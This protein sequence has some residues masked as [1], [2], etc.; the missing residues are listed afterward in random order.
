MNIF[1]TWVSDRPRLLARSTRSGVLKYFCDSNLF[2]STLSCWSL[3]TVL[4]FRRLHS[5]I[6]EFDCVP[7]AFWC[8]LSNWHLAT[9]DEAISAAV[10]LKT[11]KSTEYSNNFP[12]NLS[13][14][15]KTI[16][17]LLISAWENEESG[18]RSCLNPIL[19]SLHWP[20]SLRLRLLL[21]FRPL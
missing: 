21:L 9:I 17:H 1:T 2:S 11:K 7:P 15:I 18:R 12:K 3:N 6:D 19:G 13:I 14:Y 8:T 4:A 20:L 16:H 5:F 10:V